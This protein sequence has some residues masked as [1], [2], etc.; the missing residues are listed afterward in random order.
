MAGAQIPAERLEYRNLN[1]AARTLPSP[2]NGGRGFARRRVNRLARNIGNAG[3][4]VGTS[5][6]SLH[7][8]DLVA[9]GAKRTIANVGL[10]R[11]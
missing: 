1:Q 9:F 4:D 11:E 5:R 3:V 2:I 10:G 8:R 7:V 6:H